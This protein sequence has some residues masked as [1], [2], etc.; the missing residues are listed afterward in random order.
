MRA[1]IVPLGLI[2]QGHQS[3]A[4]FKAEIVEL[5]QIVERFCA[6]F[7]SAAVGGPPREVAGE[8]P[9]VQ[10]RAT[11]Q[12]RNENFGSPESCQSQHHAAR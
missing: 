8:T 1:A 2:D 12:E 3:V 10:T 6:G 11:R 5:Q 7:F 4:D 9:G